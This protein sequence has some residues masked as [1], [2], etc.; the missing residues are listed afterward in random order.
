MYYE[1]DF[2]WSNFKI[3]LYD[4]LGQGFIDVTF[5]QIKFARAHL[6]LNFQS[7]SI[8]TL[9]LYFKIEM[10][11]IQKLN[12]DVIPFVLFVLASFTDFLDGLLARMFKE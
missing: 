4:F 6:F 12:G 11:S 8:S 7:S 10:Q 1:T 3:E 2:H 9:L 5:C